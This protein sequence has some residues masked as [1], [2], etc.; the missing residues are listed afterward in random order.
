MLILNGCIILNNQN[1]MFFN[2]SYFGDFESFTNTTNE[3]D[4]DDENPDKYPIRF[5]IMDDKSKEIIQDGHFTFP[6]IV[7][8]ANLND[9]AI[10]VIGATSHY[11]EIVF[12]IYNYDNNT[13]AEINTLQGPGNENRWMRPQI[14]QLD[15][16]RIIIAYVENIYIF[17]PKDNSLTKSSKTLPELFNDEFNGDYRCWNGSEYVYSNT[18]V[19][20]NKNKVLIFNKIIYNP[21]D[22]SVNTLEDYG[23]NGRY[24]GVLKLNDGRVLI[25][26]RENEQTNSFI[27]NPDDNSVISEN[28]EILKE[29]NY[30]ICQ[31]NAALRNGDTLSV[32]RKGLLL[33]KH[34]L[35]S[36]QMTTSNYTE[37]PELKGKDSYGLALRIFPMNN[38]GAG[39][40]IDFYE[41]A[42]GGYSNI[43]IGF[44]SPG[45]I[46]VNFEK[47]VNMKKENTYGSYIVN[48]KNDEILFI[49]REETFVYNLEEQK[50]TKTHNKPDK[51][52]QIFEGVI[53][54]NNGDI[55]IPTQQMLLE[56]QEEF[57]LLRLLLLRPF[58][59]HEK[60]VMWIFCHD[61]CNK[62]QK[63]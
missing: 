8:A 61:G 16:N 57:Y 42:P 6:H 13:F 48:L 33:F 18:M 35:N 14:G 20:L 1:L 32:T 24:Y 9:S 25:L 46:D 34:D 52:P 11:E 59:N 2:D 58:Y 38:G 28:I 63:L 19:I 53:T 41:T 7:A 23:V 36:F 21:D 50:L 51:M 55:L 27:Y 54:T 15:D 40:V 10:L 4:I 5:W 45:S 12:A 17:D 56:I 31:S 49:G 3:Y 47:L 29:E 22:D 26:S 44:Y 60:S 43:Y 39:I 37:L 62:T 30:L